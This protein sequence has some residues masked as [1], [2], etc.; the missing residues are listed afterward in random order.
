M[1]DKSRNLLIVLTIEEEERVVD[2]ELASNVG[3]DLYME[4]CI[5]PLA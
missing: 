2:G 3:R 4:S 1:Y 5:I